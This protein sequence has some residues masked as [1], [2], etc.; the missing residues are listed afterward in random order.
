MLIKRLLI[1]V[2]CF[3]SISLTVAQPD[4]VSD[5]RFERL[6]RGVNLPFWF[7]YAPDD[8]DT[9]F[10][11]TDFALI[12]DLGFTFVRVPIDLGFVMDIESEDLLN[13]EHLAAIDRGFE[14]L[15]DH[16]LAILVDIH[17]TSL[18]DSDASNYSGALENPEFVTV[19]TRFWQSFARYLA[20][21]RGYDP[22]TMF[23]GPMN[24][25]VF[26]DDPTVWP[27]IQEALLTAIREV[28]PDHTLIATGAYWSN[29]D[30][31]IELT[32]LTD[33]NI[34]YDFHF[35][36]PF[37]FT[38]QGAEW[39]PEDVWPLRNVPYPSSPEVVE[40]L[41]DGL[42]DNARDTL[43][44]YGSENWD[45]SDLAARIAIVAEWGQANNVRLICS[46]FG[47]YGTYAP[48]DDRVEWIRQTRSLFEL[49]GIGWA[50]WEYDDAFGLVTRADN[51]DPIPDE[52][53]IDALG[54]TLP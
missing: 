19:F 11:D 40:P 45:E 46:E 9:R 30:T 3:V 33:P 27:P 25:P 34:V 7:W 49:Y 20:D 14:R 44:W 43:A 4:G 12:R 8:L 52:A 6:A 42:P 2:L 32:P 16:D 31:L 41:L 13:R 21:E 51:G 37:V 54:L 10:S 5:A 47:V 38:H 15:L 23:F 1:L 26:V 53:V 35:Y 39:G 18:A 28:A 17:S 50:M 22:E 36:E 29:I 48:A 24:E